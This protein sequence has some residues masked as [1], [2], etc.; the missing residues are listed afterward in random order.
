MFCKSFLSNHSSSFDPNNHLG[1]SFEHSNMLF[2]V[3][4]IDEKIH[5]SVCLGRTIAVLI[6]EILYKVIGHH[7]RKKKNVSRNLLIWVWYDFHND[8][9]N[10]NCKCKQSK[11]MHQKSI[12][13]VIT[14]SISSVE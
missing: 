10:Q 4:N 13:R 2:G 1:N 9:H 6:Q 7:K 14:A 8:N 5:Q 11:R 12:G 3:Q